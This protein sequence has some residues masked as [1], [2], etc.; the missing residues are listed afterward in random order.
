LA[1]ERKLLG[2]SLDL[3]SGVSKGDFPGLATEGRRKLPE[4]VAPPEP[5]EIAAAL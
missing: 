5:A 3:F 2:E 4:A 1:P